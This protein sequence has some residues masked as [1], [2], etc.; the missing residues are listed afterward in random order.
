MRGYRY[1][2]DQR[3]AD[4]IWEDRGIAF[5]DLPELIEGRV[6]LTSPS[7]QKG[8]DRYLTIGAIEGHVL[9]VVWM[10]TDEPG[11]RRII[12]ARQARKHEKELYRDR[13][14]REGPS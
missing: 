10:Y 8:E 14:A 3:K 2:W 4:K 9:V 1:T 5:E 13:I 6:T 11:V 7:P 12:T